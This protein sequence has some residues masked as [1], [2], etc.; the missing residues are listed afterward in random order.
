MNT[1]TI[2]WLLEDSEPSVRYR[3][4][5]RLLGRKETDRDV[6]KTRERIIDDPSVKKIRVM[7]DADGG[8]YGKGCLDPL[9]A[10]HDFGV[11]G[12]DPFIRKAIELISSRQTKDGAFK[13]YYGKK[14]PCVSAYS[15][16]LLMAFGE[17][18]DERTRNGVSY[19]RSIQRLDGGWLHGLNALPGGAKENAASC[20]HATLHVL[21]AMSHDEEFK[22]SKEVDRA[23]EFVLHHWETKLPI[24]NQ[25][26]MGFG[27][28]SR[29]AN[30]KYPLI[31]YHILAYASILARYPVA[32]NDRRLKD[33][34]RRILEK[35]ERDGRYR[36]ESVFKHF[37]DFEFGK[38]N[39]PSKWIT[40]HALWTIKQ[41]LGEEYL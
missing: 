18:D 2:D 37:A 23:L 41:V 20:P 38:K 25:P 10:A 17:R 39:Q 19:L 32:R 21:L 15:V 31:G 30:L 35:Q 22:N 24:P 16:G 8:F 1:K 14:I 29:F 26:G 12:T 3:T 33:V 28:G 34:A 11:S 9:I 4:L 7:Q 5:T 6:I 40:L 36:A 27:I 13:H